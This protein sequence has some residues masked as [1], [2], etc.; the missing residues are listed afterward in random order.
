V[1]L[2]TLMFRILPVFM[3]FTL[4][5]GCPALAHQQSLAS[6]KIHF[7]NKKMIVELLIDQKSIL[8]INGY[9]IE[10]VTTINESQLTEELKQKTFAYVEKGFHASNNGQEMDL[11]MTEIS[12][13]DFSNVRLVLEFTSADLIDKVDI[14][15]DLWFENSEGKHKNVATIE[16]GENTS[17]FIFADKSRHLSMEAGLEL[18]LGTTIWQFI[19]LGVEH[20]ITGYDHLLFL[21]ALILLGGSFVNILKI[22][23]SFTVAHSITL[24]LASFEVISLSSRFV[25]SVIALSILYVAIENQFVKNTAKRWML[26]FAFGLIHGFG[27]A[28]ALAETQVPKNH[29]VTSLLTF[30]VGVEIGQILIVALVLPFILYVKR[31]DWNTFLVRGASSVIGVFGLLWFIQRAFDLEILPF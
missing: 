5:F 14:D 11:Q 3:L 31:F 17:E 29:F 30:N 19:L 16:N 28:G 26:T 7:E 23:T 2:Q 18:P 4:F 15:Y 10:K 8:E 27:F 12:I 20:I 22:V 9:D 13:P 6:S 24:L 25:E 21:F 1:N